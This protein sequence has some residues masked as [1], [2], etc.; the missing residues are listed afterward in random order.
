MIAV[1]ALRFCRIARAVGSRQ[2]TF[3]RCSVFGN[4]RHAYRRADI[5]NLAIIG[6]EEVLKVGM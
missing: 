2:H 3:N 6:K 5:E 4:Y 1:P